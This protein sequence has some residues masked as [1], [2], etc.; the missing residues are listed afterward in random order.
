LKACYGDAGKLDGLTDGLMNGSS[1]W[2][3]WLIDLLAD[4]GYPIFTY[5][6]QSTVLFKRINVILFINKI[7]KNQ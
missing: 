7:N 1:E 4:R 5:L 6:S 3:T 2:I